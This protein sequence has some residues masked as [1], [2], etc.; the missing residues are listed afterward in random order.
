MY[1]Q[2]AVHRALCILGLYCFPVLVCLVSCQGSLKHFGRL[3]FHEWMSHFRQL[4]WL[5]N[6]QSICNTNVNGLKILKISEVRVYNHLY[7]G[8]D[9]GVI[10]LLKVVI[11]N[12]NEIKTHH[13]TQFYEISLPHL[14]HWKRLRSPRTK[15]SKNGLSRAARGKSSEIAGNR[16]QPSVVSAFAQ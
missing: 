12:L 3:P 1:N 16:P 2:C 11:Y 6:I 14:V 9:N 8:T 7:I 5:S 4:Y 13:S 10:L 15:Y